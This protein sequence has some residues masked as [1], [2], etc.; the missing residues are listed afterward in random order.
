[1]KSIDINIEAYMSEPSYV[2]NP[3]SSHVHSTEQLIGLPWSFELY[4]QQSIFSL[5]CSAYHN[6]LC[7]TL[8]LQIMDMRFLTRLSPRLAPSIK[9]LTGD[10]P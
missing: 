6:C 7:L 8:D 5:M 9:K 1:M 10:L 3:I 2:A 4:T